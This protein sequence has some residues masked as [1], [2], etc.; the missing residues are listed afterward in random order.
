[1]RSPPMLPL[2]SWWSATPAPHTGLSPYLHPTP[3]H[4]RPR[5]PNHHHPHTHTTPTH[6]HLGDLR[7]QH[8]APR[9]QLSL[10]AKQGGHIGGLQGR[11]ERAAGSSKKVGNKRG[12]GA[13]G[14]HIS[15]PQSMAGVCAGARAGRGVAKRR[16]AQMGAGCEV[17]LRHRKGAQ[18]VLLHAWLATL[19]RDP[20]D[21]SN[22]YR[23]MPMP[24][25]HPRW[26][27]TQPALRTNSAHP[28]THTNSNRSTHPHCHPPSGTPS[29]PH[30]QPCALLRAR[31][32]ARCCTAGQ[33][34]CHRR[35][36]QPAWAHQR[37]CRPSR[38]QASGARRRCL[39]RGAGWP[40]LAEVAQA[41]GQEMSGGGRGSVGEE[42]WHGGANEAHAPSAETVR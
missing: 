13:W 40:P 8:L 5:P 36:R 19:A 27:S 35:A 12:G 17:V 18:P 10:G 6:L 34:C 11:A 15:S 25:A 26:R 38:G 9:L 21:I 20:R 30:P 3:V 33:P 23:P 39:L 29:A 2:A 14:G 37:G 41:A 7:L 1:M 24:T 4:H 16:R 28:N 31:W 22:Y 32:H 42:G